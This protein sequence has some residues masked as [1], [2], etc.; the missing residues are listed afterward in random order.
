MYFEKQIQNR[1]R[2]LCAGTLMVL[3]LTMQSCAEM[4]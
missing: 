3:L 2:G 1:S 4:T